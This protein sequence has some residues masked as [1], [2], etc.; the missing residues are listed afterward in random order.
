VRSRYFLPSFG[1][2]DVERPEVLVTHTKEIGQILSSLHRT[3]SNIGGSADVIT[4]ISVAQLALKHR[5]NKT[6]RQRII[7][8]V[9]S[10]LPASAD[11][12]ALTRLAKKLKKNNVAVDVVSFGE[13][14]TREPNE[15]VLR[16]FVEGV[17]SGENSHFLSVPPGSRLLGDALQSSPILAGEGAAADVDAFGTGQGPSG[18]GG[19][20]E[21]GV[22]PSMD[23]ELAMVRVCGRWSS[24]SGGTNPY[25]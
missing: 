7:V 6:L 11:E 15:V 9:G 16:Q 12:K 3:S 18:G 5:T 19:E 2:D 22:D 8:F 14:E 23:P 10:P 13:D 1:T 20:F 4:A 25:F 24:L 17:S 21:F